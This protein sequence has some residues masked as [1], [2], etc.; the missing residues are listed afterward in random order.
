M[1]SPLQKKSLRLLT[2]LYKTKL[3]SYLESE[4]NFLNSYLMN[5]ESAIAPL[6]RVFTTLEVLEDMQQ[7]ELVVRKLQIKIFQDGYPSG[8]ITKPELI[9]PLHFTHSNCNLFDYDSK[10]YIQRLQWEF[11]S[12]R[13]KFVRPFYLEPVNLRN[14][15]SWSCLFLFPPTT[16]DNQQS[17]FHGDVYFIDIGVDETY[18]PVASSMKFLNKVYHPY[19]N[20]S[21]EIN[22]DVMQISKAH[23]TMY[24]CVA[25]VYK[26]ISNPVLN[27]WNIN[28]ATKEDDTQHQ[29]ETFIMKLKN[30][31]KK[32]FRF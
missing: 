32:L 8:L 10:P 7:I 13:R 15:R 12:I 18:P 16:S 27:G 31:C 29:S 19:I 11:A 5:P 3:R 2:R 24:D 17:P 28:S 6:R 21:G 22:T 14:L 30:K 26:E 25:A 23:T 9:K 1:P 20:Q 4:P